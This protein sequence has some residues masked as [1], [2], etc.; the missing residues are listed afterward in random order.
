MNDLLPLRRPTANIRNRNP[1][2]SSSM[3]T[4]VYVKVGKTNRNAVRLA[5]TARRQANYLGPHG[6]RAMRGQT[7]DVFR[8]R[9]YHRLEFPNRS[10][11]LRFEEFVEENCDSAVYTERYRVPPERRR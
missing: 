8:R 4:A 5:D 6:F 9:G 1:N 3:R 2:R 7:D 10:L 11:A